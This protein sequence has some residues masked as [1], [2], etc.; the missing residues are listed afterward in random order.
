MRSGVREHAPHA[1]TVV[2]CT[3]YAVSYLVTRAKRCAEIE[4]AWGIVVLPFWSAPSVG[5]RCPL[6]LRRKHSTRVHQRRK[7]SARVSLSAEHLLFGRQEYGEE[8]MRGTKS[9]L[10]AQQQYNAQGT[11]VGF[12][13]ALI[14]TQPSAPSGFCPSTYSL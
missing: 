10:L 9:K 11:I 3:A 5:R 12:L 13:C 2:A 7:H 4:K 8:E 6:H 14:T 1:R